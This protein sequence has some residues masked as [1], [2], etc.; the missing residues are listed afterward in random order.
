MLGYAYNLPLSIVLYL[1]MYCA[2]HS[3]F[4]IVKLL[5][6]V[7][8]PMNLGIFDT[9]NFPE[10]TSYFQALLTTKRFLPMLHNVGY[11]I[12]FSISISTDAH[13]IGGSAGSWRKTQ[14]KQ[15]S[16]ETIQLPPANDD[17]WIL[18]KRRNQFFLYRPWRHLGHVL[19]ARRIITTPTEATSPPSVV[20]AASCHGYNRDDPGDTTHYNSI[21]GNCYVKAGDCGSDDLRNI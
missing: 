12:F 14:Q 15:C 17:A 1:L 4:S 5:N 9:D 6:I 10:T 11:Y 19:Y 21:F 8:L 13:F 18:L 3:F 20:T 7:P 2:L 16:S